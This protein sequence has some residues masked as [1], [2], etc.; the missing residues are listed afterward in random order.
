MI[1]LHAARARLAARV[2]ELAHVPATLDPRNVGA[3]AVIVGP[4]A[5]TRLSVNGAACALEIPVTYLVAPPANADAL[6]QLDA[7]LIA[8]MTACGATDATFGAYQVGGAEYPA[9]EM[10]VTVSVKG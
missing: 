10:T 8:V 4:A 7:H 2:A 9:Y 1:D 3:H 6:R 5:V